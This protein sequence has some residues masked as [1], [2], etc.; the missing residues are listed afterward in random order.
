MQRVHDAI[1]A[2][3]KRVAVNKAMAPSGSGREVV[4]A[5]L[6]AAL[7]AC[8]PRTDGGEK[9]AARPEFI[10][11]GCSEP[12]AMGV[13]AVVLA[14]VA[15]VL[16]K[17]KK[18]PEETLTRVSPPLATPLHFRLGSLLH[19]RRLAPR[20][21][22]EASS[23]ADVA[24]AMDVDD[25]IGDDRTAASTSSVHEWR[26][27][28]SDISAESANFTTECYFLA[29]RA[30]QTAIMPTVS[31]CQEQI[32]DLYNLLA[33]EDFDR[34]RWPAAGSHAD[35]LL[36]NIVKL[37]DAYLCTLVHESMASAALRL[38]SLVLVSVAAVLRGAGNAEEQARL[39]A[40]VPETMV[41]DGI[42]FASFVILMGHPDVFA[43]SGSLLT[44]M[45]VWPFCPWAAPG[46]C[47]SGE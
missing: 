34:R 15:P 1:H 20:A 23:T 7:Y 32:S 31:R 18:S 28:V 5:W 43:V 40:S 38:M 6:S 12:F 3:L 14:F 39:A 10:A 47:A 17:F 9:S 44:S 11:R 46:T 22:A 42:L 25:E 27:A 45:Q 36:T 24:N 29:T 33:R 19:G 8:A 13:A 4:L 30:L 41:R 26:A 35:R 37:E 21:A 2:I 16:D